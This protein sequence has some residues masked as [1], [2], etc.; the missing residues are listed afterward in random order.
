M[1]KEERIDRN[2]KLF[3]VNTYQKRGMLHINDGRC[4]HVRMVFDFKDFD[5]ERSAFRAFNNNLK[6]CG[7]CF[8]EE[9]SGNRS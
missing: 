6:K 9:L 5:D 3:V 2:K 4:C 1:K 7:I 8:K